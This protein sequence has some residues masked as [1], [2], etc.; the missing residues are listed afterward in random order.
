MTL[1]TYDLPTEIPIPL[2]KQD[3]SSD[4]SIGR[5]VLPADMIIPI[6]MTSVR[7]QFND[8]QCDLGINGH[9]L[10]I[11]LL[12]YN[13]YLYKFAIGTGGNLNNKLLADYLEERNILVSEL[14]RTYNTT[15]CN[16]E[17]LSPK[18]SI[19]LIKEI[20]GLNMSDLATLFNI[21]R[22]TVYAWL[23]GQEPAPASLQKIERISK[24]AAIIKSKN[25]QRIEKISKR[26]LFDGK[27]F[28][29]KLIE[30][31][32]INELH[33]NTLFVLSEK[34]NTSR[35]TTKGNIISDLPLSNQLSNY[36]TYH[37]NSD[38]DE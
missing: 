32:D 37:H 13:R 17:L 34:E 20:L 24:I 9:H 27:S 36:P 2:I 10:N 26:Q 15:N 6:E 11:E 18:E 38:L 8:L 19:T 28:F 33:F 30:N 1:Q 12:I 35:H 16:N 22:P 7:S 29:D 5:V 31:E 25:I 3:F 4:T 14:Q 21:S 23:N